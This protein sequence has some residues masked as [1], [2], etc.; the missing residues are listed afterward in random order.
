MLK[1]LTA[2]ALAGS[3]AAAAQTVAIARGETV[4]VTIV[5]DGTARATDRAPIGPDSYETANSAAFLRGDYDQAVGGKSMAIGPDGAGAP[6]P[7]PLPGKLVFRFVRTPGRDASL[8]SI[9]NG[10]GGALIYRAAIRYGDGVR[11]TDVCLVMPGKI[12]NEFWPYPIGALDLSGLRLV[13][14]RPGDPVKC[15]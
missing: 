7:T 1:L 2:A 3:S 10:Y 9:R 12:G 6:A 8:L 14:W 5:D 15:E 4:T 13:P 11:P